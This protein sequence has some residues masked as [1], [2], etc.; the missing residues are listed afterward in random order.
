MDHEKIEQAAGTSG[1]PPAAKGQVSSRRRFL[2]GTSLA[3]PAVMTLHSVAA[4]AQARSSA[5][6]A[7]DTQQSGFAPLTVDQ[8]DYF[9]HSVAVYDTLVKKVQGQTVV[10]EGD[11]IIA[12]FAGKDSDG[13]D[14]IRKL[15]G[16]VVPEPLVLDGNNLNQATKSV[17]YPLNPN[18][19][20]PKQSFDN[21]F[22]IVLFDSQSGAVVSVGEPS[23]TLGVTMVTS[24]TGACLHS[25][26]GRTV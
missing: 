8:D 16:S 11:G 2:K 26:W 13:T 10:Y 3:L 23:T 17:N 14:V 20:P 9:R 1:E 22:A 5:Y 18:Y 19:V 21:Q 4:Q 7:N 24:L 25:L 6:C 15:D 12:F